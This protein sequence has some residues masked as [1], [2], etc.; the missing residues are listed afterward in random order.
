MHAANV[1]PTDSSS[2]HPS[3]LSINRVRE[4]GLR[5]CQRIRW[6]VISA[7]K[8]IRYVVV[9]EFLQDVLPCFLIF[10]IQSVVGPRSA[11]HNFHQAFSTTS[12][13]LISS[14]SL[15]RVSITI[16]A[17]MSQNTWC[18]ACIGHPASPQTRNGP[19]FWAPFSV[20]MGPFGRSW[21]SKFRCK[22]QM[23]SPLLGL[24]LPF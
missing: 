19:L 24:G 20:G 5:C 1:E 2:F 10:V 17:F 13:A 16:S 4:H 9:P 18:A 15:L 3:T 22:S 14:G 23:S 12:L 11:C 21:G 6:Y 7:T 8:L